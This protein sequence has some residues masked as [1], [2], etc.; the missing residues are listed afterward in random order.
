MDAKFQ[1]VHRQLASH[2]E[3]LL[4]VAKAVY[5]LLD[6]GPNKKLNDDEE[7]SNLRYELDE[8]FGFQL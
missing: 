8:A 7:R 2:E 1:T 6:D 3:K 4:L 5:A